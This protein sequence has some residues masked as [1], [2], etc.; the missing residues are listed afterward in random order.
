MMTAYIIMHNII[1]NN[2]RDDNL[3]NQVWQFQ[4]EH[5]LNS[6]SIRIMRSMIKTLTINS[7][8]FW[9]RICGLMGKQLVIFSLNFIYLIVNFLYLLIVNY[10]V[11]FYLMVK[12]IQ[13]MKNMA[14]MTG[15]K[16]G[17]S[18]CTSIPNKFRKILTLL[19]SGGQSKSTKQT[20][21]VLKNRLIRWDVFILPFS[22]LRAKKKLNLELGSSVWHTLWVA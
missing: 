9:L 12:F 2:E 21:L 3:F 16:W 1:I 7:K 20:Y 18:R 8:L 22:F 13:N 17:A 10:I 19:L 11:V 6:F 5:H 4:G 15:P 14:K